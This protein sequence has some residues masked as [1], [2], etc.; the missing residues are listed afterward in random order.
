ML[1]WIKYWYKLWPWGLRLGLTLTYVLLKYVSGGFQGWWTLIRMED[2]GRVTT[3]RRLG[4]SITSIGFVLSSLF[5]IVGCYAD[6]WSVRNAGGRVVS[7]RIQSVHRVVPIYILF[8]QIVHSPTAYPTH[9]VVYGV[10]VFRGTFMYSVP[11]YHYALVW[12]SIQHPSQN[13]NTSS[14]LYTPYTPN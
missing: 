6:P 4:L 13:S 8:R 1:R 2:H 3:G 12:R 9:S 7:L 5:C 14:I 10:H 11:T